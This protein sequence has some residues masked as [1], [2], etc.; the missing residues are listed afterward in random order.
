EPVRLIAVGG[1]G[2]Y[3]ARLVP[4][5]HDVG[6]A[7]IETA[8][9]LCREL[10][11]DRLAARLGIPPARAR[12]LP[13]GISIVRALM[14]RLRPERVEVARSGIR[15]GL[16]LAAFAEMQSPGSILTD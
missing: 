5:A 13:A 1:T 4:D 12:V 7:E 8:L 11:S 3:L 6:S 15:T 10:P 2:E 14:D 16:L 9:G